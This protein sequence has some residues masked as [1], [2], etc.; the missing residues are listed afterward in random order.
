MFSS[1][2]MKGINRNLDESLPRIIE[3]VIA[4]EGGHPSYQ[5]Y[6]MDICADDWVI[7]RKI[8]FIPL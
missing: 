5:Y 7:N 6:M 8:A 4:E 2:Y 1:W 3:V